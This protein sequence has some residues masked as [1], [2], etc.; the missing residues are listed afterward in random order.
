MTH[1]H[2][3]PSGTLAA[4]VLA[5]ALFGSTA[6]AQTNVRTP[7]QT[8]RAAGAQQRAG[9]QHAPMSTS[10]SFKGD[11]LAA[12]TGKPPLQ[13]LK[14]YE[15][16]LSF[17]Q[18]QQ[19][20]GVLERHVELRGLRRLVPSQI[21]AYDHLAARTTDL[22]VRWDE[23]GS[24]PIYLAARPLLR[25]IS[26]LAGE[27]EVAT[28]RRFLSVFGGLLRVDDA[29]EAFHPIHI[30]HED[31]G[32]TT[33]RMQQTFRGVPIWGKQL[34]VQLGASG[35]VELCMG[36]HAVTP[37]PDTDAH[38]GG[39]DAAAAERAARDAVFAHMPQ[40]AWSEAERM[41][42]AADTLKVE[43]VYFMAE[44]TGDARPAWMVE[45][46]TDIV[47][48]QR[49]FVDARTGMVL[50]RYGTTC[51]DGPQKASA[52]DA[53]GRTVT[54]DTYQHLGTHY[55]IDASRPMFKA[56]QSVF[57]GNT[58]GTITTLDARNT[59]LATV[60]QVT[61]AT[62]TWNDASSVSAHVNAAQ[63]YE[64]FRTVHGRNAID[65][66]GSTIL[67]VVNVTQG[68]R[69]LDNAFWNGK[70]MIYGNGDVLFR[71][72][73]AAL[74]VAAHEMTHGVTEHS[75]NLEYLGQSGALN[76]AFSDIFGVMVDRDDWKVGEDI[77]RP[78]PSFPNN[79][80]R[81]LSDPH[82]G[83]TPGGDAWQPKHMNEYQNL[84]LD[85][86]QGGV[87]INSGIPN[88]AAYL[89]A[90][91]ARL[92][93]QGR[94]ITERV[95][96]RALTTKLTTQSRFVDFRLAIV[97]AAEELYPQN[98]AVAAVMRAACDAVGITDG[99]PTQGPDDLPPVAG[100]DRMLVTSTDPT[101]PFYL[102]TVI[103]PAG[104]N[105]F[106]SLTRTP[107][108]R[109]PSISD[110]GAIAVFIDGD[111]NLR[112]IA[113]NPAAPA[114]QVIDNS[115]I[116]N[117]VAI[118]RD[119]RLLALTT[120]LN[121]TA[122]HIFD[123]SQTTPVL[124]TFPVYT[125]NYSNGT[126]PNVAEFADAMDFSAGS[127]TIVFDCY[128]EMNVDGTT[129]GFWDINLMEVWDKASATFG[130]GRIARLFPQE[131][132]VDIGNPVFARNRQTVIAFDVQQPGTSTAGILAYDLV[133]GGDPVLISESVYGVP[134]YPSFRGDDRALSFGAPNTQATP[135][136]WTVPLAAD[137]MTPTAQASGFVAGAQ[138]PVWY[139]IGQ[140]PVA[141]ERVAPPSP[142]QI[143]PSWPNPFQA[144][145]MTRYSLETPA[146]VRISV[147]DM[148][149][150]EVAVLGD[151]WVD[152]GSHQT[153]WNGAGTDGKPVPAGMYVLRLSAAGAQRTQSVLLVR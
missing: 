59:E 26:N 41:L 151:G 121:E 141:V 143:W 147:H 12:R 63:T 89:A 94:D 10:R 153:S 18:W 71:P 128:N 102:W 21:L 57:P 30:L 108:L 139:R 9:M 83:A 113:L 2:T 120:T 110:D 47:H 7:A 73:A 64:Y 56:A 22:D 109:K 52:R 137:V 115:G 29:G 33:M 138:F 3:F 114:E 134:G 124:K 37:A 25:G 72:L 93:G 99:T 142:L 34:V 70:F 36:R 152:A 19:A 132:G 69:G 1:R 107:V 62:N 16:G 133:D 86:D 40:H 104:P 101:D 148:L 32:A 144:T 46:R 78:N 125:P 68:G 75:A 92:G 131:P 27:T 67:S 28:V 53:L 122:I 82:N 15:V 85:V 100:I 17:Q 31:G 14:L 42:L 98:P 96:Y 111:R 50:E 35:D 103:A 130:S 126:L 8:I 45:L 54:I 74:D 51:A 20:I 117:S 84:P 5:V 118:S 91:D 13:K 119:K 55:M 11:V 146:V 66:K 61:S 77:I 60:T 81:D 39:L 43:R 123:V 49:V 135:V 79:A 87:H 65:N 76:E 80:L 129:V 24:L 44:Q 48:R 58:V 90:T 106:Q 23:T 105:D 4:L 116:W 95:F 127:E 38:E 88:H 6:H 97:R 140:R 149:G 150:R 112:A 145:T 136:I